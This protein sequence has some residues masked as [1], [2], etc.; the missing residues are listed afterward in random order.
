MKKW[1]Q[2]NLIFM[3]YGMQVLMFILCVISNNGTIMMIVTGFFACAGAMQYSEF[4]TRRKMITELQ[5][6]HANAVK[7]Q[8]RA[9]HV[10]RIYEK[11][12]EG[13]IPDID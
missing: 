5:E 10:R 2:H 7:A 13:D 4:V 3:A 12:I 11:L 1:F 9:D 8:A 6:A